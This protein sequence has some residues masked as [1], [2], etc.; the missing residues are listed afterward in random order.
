M[1]FSIPVFIDKSK[2]SYTKSKTKER[3]NRRE[4]MVKY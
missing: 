4:K 1:R 3:L 2:N